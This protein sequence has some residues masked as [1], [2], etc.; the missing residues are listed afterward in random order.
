[1]T[2]HTGP[3]AD[4]DAARVA[5]A[6]LDA[7][8]AD[9]AGGLDFRSAVDAHQQWRLR[10]QAVVEGRSRE[11]LDPRLVGRDDQCALGKWIQGDGARRFR[12][13]RHFAELRARH[14]YFHVCAG[15]ALVL[16]Q[17]GH[18]EAAAAEIG[19]TGEFTRLSR[20][21]LRELTSLFLRIRGAAA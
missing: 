8:G 11:Q 16:A 9:E 4:A 18:R 20:E 7:A 21:L 1:M 2:M 10:L 12:G 3:I 14:A 5:H 19:P 13:Q 17:S 15:R 6:A